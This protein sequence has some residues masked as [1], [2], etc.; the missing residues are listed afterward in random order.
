ME[1]PALTVDDLPRL[2][3]Q[4]QQRLLADP[5]MGPFFAGLD[6]RTHVPHIARFWAMALFGAPGYQGNVMTIHVQLNTRLSRGDAP[7]ERRLAHF[8]AALE[9]A[10]SGSKV[11][12]ANQRARTITAVMQHRFTNR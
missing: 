1:W 2:I 7:F 10:H 9:A 6:L 5:L 12:G 3:G 4:F 8:G 11:E